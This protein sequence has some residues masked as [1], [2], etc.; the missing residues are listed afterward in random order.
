MR[1]HIAFK[2]SLILISSVTVYAQPWKMYPYHKQG[3]LINFPED[4][5]AHSEFK[6][7][8]GTE[9]WYVN[10]HLEGESTQRRYS[11]MLAIFNYQFRIFDLA[12]ETDQ[13][14]HSFTDFG[15]LSLSNTA[16]NLIFTAASGETDRWVTKEDSAGQLLP[17][18]YHI[19]TG[20]GQNNLKVDLDAKNPPLIIG[21]DG[22]VTVGSGDSYY[23][24]QTLLMVTGSLTFNG[25]PEPVNGTA[26]ID[27][28]YGPFF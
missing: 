16:L 6:P 7:G 9:W 19:E 8:S 3:T 22:L 10:L 17:F 11:A 26:W 14:F 12:D 15:S 13:E 25:S 24:S 27:H 1:R 20:N 5:G 18:Q 21:G 4:E 2:I 28:Q 23:Y